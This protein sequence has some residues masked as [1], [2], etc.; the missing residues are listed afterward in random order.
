MKIAVNT[1]LLIKGK[2][3]GIGWFTYENLKRITRGHPEHEFFFLFDRKFHPDFIF[4][5]N[6]KPLVVHPQARHPFLYY[7]WFEH[8][9]PRALKKINADLFFSPDGYLSLRTKVPSVNVF[10]DLNFEH[11]PGDLPLIERKFYRHYFPEYARKALRIATVSEYSKSDIVRLYG[12]D[13]NKIDVVYNGANE[14]FEPVDEAVKNQIRK[15]YAN[16]SPYF[17]F[18]GSLH[19]RKNLARLFPAFDLFKA[20][21]DQGIK[22]VI[23]GE[24]KWWTEAIERAYEQMDHKED[25]IFTGRLNVDQLHKV[26]ASAF[27]LT[28]VSYFEGFGIPILEAF[29]C[30]VPVITSNI[31][32]MPEVAGD[33][34]LLVDPLSVNSISDAMKKMAGDGNLREM[35]I[36]KGIERSKMFSWQQSSER[37]WKTIEKALEGPN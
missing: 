14:S 1:R 19:P 30:H 29:Y 37:L 7:L 28:Y 4:S 9:I 25:V 5:E 31:T 12:V 33:A 8:A 24:K 16:G 20:T 21:D 26:I 11:Y 22:L 23:V 32:S 10:H 27:A 15:Q 3:E 17:L 18:V 2:L 34:A 35:L 36:A 13:E 6:V